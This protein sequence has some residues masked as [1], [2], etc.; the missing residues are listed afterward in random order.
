MRRLWLWTPLV[1]VGG[2]AKCGRV[3]EP[4]AWQTFVHDVGCWGWRT[5]W[6]NIWR[7]DQPE[8]E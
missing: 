1:V 2:C 8:D 3:R 7:R 4:D 5:A 6:A